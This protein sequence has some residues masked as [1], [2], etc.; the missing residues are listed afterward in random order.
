M[1]VSNLDSYMIRNPSPS[2]LTL[3]K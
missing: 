3:D 2:T 1:C